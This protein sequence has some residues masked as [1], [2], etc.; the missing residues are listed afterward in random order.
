MNLSE[1]MRKAGSGK[2]ANMKNHYD[3]YLTNMLRGPIVH[4]DIL[5]NGGTFNMPE[6]KNRPHLYDPLLALAPDPLV[7]P[8]PP[9]GGTYRVVPDK[10]LQD[11]GPA[12]IGRIVLVDFEHGIGK[13]TLRE[14]LPRKLG[15]VVAHFGDMVDVRM[16]C[17][18]YKELRKL[19][20]VCDKKHAFLQAAKRDLAVSESKRKELEEELGEAFD[21]LNNEK[22]KRAV[23]VQAREA[24]EKRVVELKR[25]HFGTPRG[26]SFDPLRSYS[27]PG[28]A[29]YCSFPRIADYAKLEMTLVRKAL[30]DWHEVYTHSAIVY[31][32]KAPEPEM[33]TNGDGSRVEVTKMTDAHLHYA[34]AK[35]Y[36]GEYQ[37]AKCRALGLP[38]LKREAARRLQVYAGP[39]PARTPEQMKEVAQ[40]KNDLAWERE[41][42][43]EQ[44]RTNSKMSRELDDTKNLLKKAIDTSTAS[45]QIA[46]QYDTIKA[47]Q[48]EV[49]QLRESGDRRVAEVSKMYCEANDKALKERQAAEAACVETMK[50]RSQLE[51][52]EREVSSLRA[53]LDATQKV[54]GQLQDRLTIIR[55]AT[56]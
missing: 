39:P 53:N 22:L 46:N 7:M 1:R 18:P 35:G 31:A 19:Q 33:W 10:K 5:K 26:M 27:F 14:H 37:D 41:R 56:H 24:A 47:L 32:L 3:P 17:D 4:I 21:Q 28:W 15:T 45:Q 44:G 12:A 42:R 11:Y 9:Y 36:R 48:A 16:G 34:I 2:E 38:A 40:L 23:D 50:L 43:E 49:A 20:E 13:A 51:R 29:N 25:L 6:D 8:S 30:S 52:T 54:A 55:D